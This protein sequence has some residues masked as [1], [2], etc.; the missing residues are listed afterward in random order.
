MTTKQRERKKRRRI[1]IIEDFLCWAFIVLSYVA[2]AYAVI[3]DAF[4]EAPTQWTITMIAMALTLQL[5]TM[6]M[7]DAIEKGRRRK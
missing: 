6:R 2:M 1:Q 5:V 3:M 7:F 4:F